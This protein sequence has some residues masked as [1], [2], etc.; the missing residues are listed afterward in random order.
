MWL[1]PVLALALTAPPAT[2]PAPSPTYEDLI[3]EATAQSEQGNPIE[4]A[5]LFR[6]AFEAMPAEVKRQVVGEDLAAT[7]HYD[8]RFTAWRYTGDI[9]HLEEAKRVLEVLLA[10]QR[11][12]V[13]AGARPSTSEDAE[14]KLAL[15]EEE[16]AYYRKR[17]ASSTDPVPPP[18][19]EPT[20]QS[21]TGATRPL[22]PERPDLAM[23]IALLAV[24][25]TLAVGGLACVIG[26]EAGRAFNR[27]KWD[28]ASEAT[29]ENDPNFLADSKKLANAL[30]ISGA[31]ALA[32][33][34]ATLVPGAIF[35]RRRT[36]SSL[37]VGPLPSRHA[38]GFSVRFAF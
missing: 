30:T 27:N 14:Q 10:E 15:V 6:Q 25:S 23:P 19:V 18:R 9:V 33:G 13:A 22:R 37:A 5:D 7:L 28:N 1:R 8:A 2:G 24:G 31:V 4:G 35:Y 36:A 11:A 17:N 38:K 34:V 29:R 3:V 16:I 26:G 21:D 20:P 32:A 12:A